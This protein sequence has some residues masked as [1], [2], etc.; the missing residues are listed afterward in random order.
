MFDLPHAPTHAVVLPHVLAFNAP[1]APAAE[2]RI[3]AAFGAPTAL[4]GLTTL[5][6]TL[7]APRALRDI[8]MPADGIAAAADAIVAAA[9]A[10]NPTPVTTDSIS[11]LLRAAWAGKEPR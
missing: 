7:D 3:A 11:E 2:R 8:G 9:P 10:G 5:R 4:D 6:E 1:N